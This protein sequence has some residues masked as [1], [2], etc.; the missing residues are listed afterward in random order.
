MVFFVHGREW[1]VGSSTASVGV[2]L[3]HLLS[4]TTPTCTKYDHVY[5]H[6]VRPHVQQPGDK[7][8]RINILAPPQLNDGMLEP[9]LAVEADRRASR[10]QQQQHDTRRTQPCPLSGTW[11]TYA[12]TAH[13]H[14]H[15]HMCTKHRRMQ[16][17]RCNGEAGD[18]HLH[19][20]G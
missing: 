3:A 12:R 6:Q 19:R 15:R 1:Q 7:T 17:Q 4:H 9:T 14:R 13:R 20:Q 8:R 11:S 10:R 18:S 2:R 5:L 16:V